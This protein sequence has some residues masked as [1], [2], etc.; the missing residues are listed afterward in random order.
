[1][2][3][4]S[5]LANNSYLSSSSHRM[6]RCVS[7]VSCL[8]VLCFNWQ[9]PIQGSTPMPQWPNGFFGGCFF[10]LTGQYANGCGLYYERPVS[11]VLLNVLK[12]SASAIIDG[13]WFQS[14][15]DANIV[16]VQSGDTV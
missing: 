11:R 8:L 15:M 3:L 5:H 12:V 13:S 1:M 6:S 4:D 16:H 9:D 14:L 2:A 10:V 7:P